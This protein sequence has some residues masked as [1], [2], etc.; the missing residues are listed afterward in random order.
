MTK[1]ALDETVFNSGKMFSSQGQPTE[2]SLNTFANPDYRA[3]PCG[4][5]NDNWIDSTSWADLGHVS[6]FDNSF[7]ISVR[8]SRSTDN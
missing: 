4:Q 8:L 2:S 7:S 3:E 6:T 1:S 5:G